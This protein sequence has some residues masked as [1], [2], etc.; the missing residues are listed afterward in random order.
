MAVC[1]TPRHTTRATPK[2]D[3]FC[4]YARSWPSA[5]HARAIGEP[6][7]AQSRYRRPIAYLPR[8]LSAAA[9]R[10][11]SGKP[12]TAPCTSFTRPGHDRNQSRHRRQAW[13]GC[14]SRASCP[15]S[16]GPRASDRPCQPARPAG[17]SWWAGG[18]SLAPIAKVK[19]PKNPWMRPRSTKAADCGRSIR[20]RLQRLRLALSSRAARTGSRSGSD[21]A[22]RD[23]TIAIKL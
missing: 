18:E 2:W 16:R 11:L 14:A 5:A 20:R 19:A 1:K 8:G 7:L 15:G 3:G 6:L 4:S 9:D 17:V 23:A 22:L 12:A 10:L 21:A 13:Q